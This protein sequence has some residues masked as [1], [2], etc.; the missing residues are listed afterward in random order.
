MTKI[1]EELLPCPFCGSTDIDVNSAGGENA[2]FCNCNDCGVCQDYDNK[3]TKAEAI[4]AWN[5]RTSPPPS[6]D[7][8][9]VTDEI[10]AERRRQIEVERWAPEHDDKHERGEMASAAG[11][12]ALAAGSHDYRWVLRGSPVNDYLA[13]AMKLWP[14]DV[15]WFKPTDRRRD[16][17]KAGALIVAE[18][19]R[20]DRALPTIKEPTDE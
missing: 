17:V 5:L 1:S 6:G 14:W 19:E 3:W 15:S 2:A 9:E 10:A 12:Y 7:A 16:L 18:I 11:V 13:A 20:L 4:S 8:G